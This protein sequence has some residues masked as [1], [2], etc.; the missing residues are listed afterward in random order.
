MGSHKTAISRNKLSAPMNYLFKNHLIPG[1]ALDYG[2]GK[3]FDADWLFMDSY[4]P[5][6]RPSFPTK[7]YDTITCIYVLNVIE[8]P[9]ERQDVL[10]AI[11][12]LLNPKGIAY[13]AVRNDKDKLKGKTSKGW[14][15][16]IVLDLHVVRTT[17]G[18]VIYKLVK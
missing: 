11:K 17:K 4:D 10:N 9:G 12:S 15:G 8:S 13:V 16:H 2:C 18:Y 6:F 7:H 3:G 14:Q 1:S 5:Y